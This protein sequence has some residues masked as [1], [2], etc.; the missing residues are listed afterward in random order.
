MGVQFSVLMHYAK[1]HIIYRS[2]IVP[3]SL[4]KRKR[5]LEVRET[6]NKF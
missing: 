4:L 6:K 2:N 5:T 1:I 3:I